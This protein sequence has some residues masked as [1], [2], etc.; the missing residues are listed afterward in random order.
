M[1][2]P[3]RQCQIGKPLK[4]IIKQVRSF[5]SFQMVPTHTSP[6]WFEGRG[7][8]G[9]RVPH[10]RFGYLFAGTEL[11]TNSL[12]ALVSCAVASAVLIGRLQQIPSSLF[13]CTNHLQIVGLPRSIWPCKFSHGVG[14]LADWTW[15][16]LFDFCDFVFD[17]LPP[18]VFTV[19]AGQRALTRGS[20]LDYDSVDFIHLGAFLEPS[21]YLPCGPQ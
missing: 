4:H 12:P 3:K 19:S 2:K 15:F 20:L 13:G 7:V 6:R 16:V 11:H 14:S 8:L 5:T 18:R 21:V 10:N 9:T 1:K 17:V